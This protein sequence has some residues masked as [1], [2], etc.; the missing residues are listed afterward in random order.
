MVTEDAVGV[1]TRAMTEVQH[2]ENEAQQIID[3]NQEEGQ[4]A[5]QD[6]GEIAQDP[7][8]TLW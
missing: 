4:R 7:A 8:M 2:M 5:A 1:Q 6:T 3:N